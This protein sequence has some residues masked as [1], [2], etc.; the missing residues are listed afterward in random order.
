MVDPP[1]LG[2][3]SSE[4]LVGGRVIDPNCIDCDV[5]QTW[6]QACQTSHDICGGPASIPLKLINCKSRAVEKLGEHVPYVALSYVWGKADHQSYYLDDGGLLAAELPKTIEDAIS[7]SLALR[8]EYLWVDKYCINQHGPEKAIEIGRMDEIYQGAEVVIID[9]AGKDPNLG[10]AGVGRRRNR[11]PQVSAGGHTSVSLFGHPINN[12]RSSK[13]ASRGWTYQEA[14]LARRRLFFTED[15]VYFECHVESHMETLKQAVIH[16]EIGAPSIIPS[17][18]RLNRGKCPKFLRYLEEYSKREL[19]YPSDALNAFLGVLRSFETQKG[20][21]RHY[22]GVPIMPFCSGSE[23]ACALEGFLR[24]LC[25]SSSESKT[26]RRPQFPSWS[27]AGWDCSGQGVI[28]HSPELKLKPL[29]SR[30]QVSYNDK[31]LDWPEFW[32]RHEPEPS[33][34]KFYAQ[35]P[36]AELHITGRV[37]KFHGSREASSCNHCQGFQ[38]LRL[39]STTYR[40]T[41]LVGAPLMRAYLQQLPAGM[42]RLTAVVLGG[43]KGMLD[44]MSTLIVNNMEEV[45]DQSEPNFKLVLLLLREQHDAK[46]ASLLGTP[47]RFERVG[48]MALSWLSLQQYERS[49]WYLEATEQDLIVV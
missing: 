39:K 3:G 25:W 30:L 26:T 31:I 40:S 21:F 43:A 1:S 6:I 12:V 46:A 36:P 48:L 42:Q 8:F 41:D 32:A 44:R 22:W 35:S 45:E 9:V 14:V 16:P 29:L 13:L 34:V 7:V 49:E 4:H 27:W 23:S 5:L 10:L 20:L 15:Q 19:T 37:I 18:M 24:G 47:P 11:Q 28:F 38:K 2:N 17:D 33:T